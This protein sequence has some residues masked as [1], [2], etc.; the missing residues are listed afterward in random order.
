LVFLSRDP[1]AFGGNEQTGTAGLYIIEA[2]D[3]TRLRL[4]GFH[5]V[6]AG[7]TT[8]CINQCRFLWS[9]GPFHSGV[10]HQPKS[11]NGQPVWVTGVADPQAP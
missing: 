1:R 7:H 11:W 3:P 6:P 4:L 8:A 10:G 9:G 5:A 2:H